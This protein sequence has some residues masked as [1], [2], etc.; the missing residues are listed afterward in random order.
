MS[1]KQARVIPKEPSASVLMRHSYNVHTIL[2]GSDAKDRLSNSG[3]KPTS[4][5]FELD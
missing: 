3:P 4:N 1:D 5:P 2:C